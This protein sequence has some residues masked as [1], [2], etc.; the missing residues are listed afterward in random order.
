MCGVALDSKR[1]LRTSTTC[2]GIHYR[3]LQDYIRLHNALIGFGLRL[4]QDAKGLVIDALK[5]SWN[6]ERRPPASPFFDLLNGGRAVGEGFLNHLQGVIR[7][8]DL[9]MRCRMARVIKEVGLSIVL[10]LV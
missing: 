8:H 5:T 3:Q 1:P 9:G 4:Q 2:I 7:H 10:F 6:Y